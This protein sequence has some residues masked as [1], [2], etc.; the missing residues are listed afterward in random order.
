MKKIEVRLPHQLP[1]AEVR[2]RIDAALAK[3]RDEYAEHVR[4][5]EATW[6]TE[7]RLDLGL[8]VMGMNIQAEMDNM[9]AELVVRVGVPAMAALFAGRIQ[10]GIEERLGGLLA[11]TP[12]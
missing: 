9:P 11:V 2:R 5:L 12:A 3:A 10:A 7:N 4:E 6:A 8:T 1:E